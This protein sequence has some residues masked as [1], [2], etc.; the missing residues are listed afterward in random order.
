M[1]I[2][3]FDALGYHRFKRRI[4][5]VRVPA[6]VEDLVGELVNHEFEEEILGCVVRCI[7]G[8]QVEECDHGVDADG[9]GG[10]GGVVG[11]EGVQD[12]VAHGYGFELVCEQVGGDEEGRVGDGGGQGLF[13]DPFDELFEWGEANAC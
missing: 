4:P 2:H 10:L 11:A 12:V 7:R 1:P 8:H 5:L 3:H 6:V 9:G 13:V